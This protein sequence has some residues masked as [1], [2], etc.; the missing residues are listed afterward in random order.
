MSRGKSKGIG[1]STRDAVL[2]GG[3]S[4]PKQTR[5]CYRLQDI[6]SDGR[7]NRIGTQQCVCGDVSG[8]HFRLWHAPCTVCPV[9]YPTLFRRLASALW[10][11]WGDQGRDAA[12]QIDFGLTCSSET[13]SHPRHPC[14]ASMALALVPRNLDRKGGRL[15]RW[16]GWHWLLL[17]RTTIWSPQISSA[18][19]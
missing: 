7:S 2:E 15:L 8:R 16:R 12:R 14:E 18:C 11:W 1:K 6:L 4:Y 3:L 13:S 10:R 5:G 9:R 17:L 19:L